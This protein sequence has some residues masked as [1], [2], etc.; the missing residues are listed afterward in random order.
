MALQTGTAVLAMRRELVGVQAPVR[1]LSTR[2]ATTAPALRQLRTATTKAGS[3]V[4]K[5]GRSAATA[6]TRIRA[7][8]GR[9]RGPLGVLGALA[10]GAGVF[11]SV[12][13]LL[14]SYTPK[15]TKF[16]TLFGTAMT[17]GSIA[18]TAINTAMKA[19]PLG[20]VL[21]IVTPLVACLVDYAVNS[22]TGQQTIQQVFQAAL[23]GFKAAWAF[24]APVIRGW[25][26]TIS[27]VFD[28]VQ[29]TVGSVLKA[30]GSAISSGFQGAGNAISSATHA[31]TS[32]V[33]GAW[34]GFKGVIQPV[35]NWL[36][37]TLPSAFTR[38]RDA[39]SKSLHGM[40]NFLSTGIQTVAG[41]V[42]GPVKGLIAFANWIIDGLN[43]LSFSFFGKKFGVHLSKIP[44]LADGGVVLPAAVPGASAVQPLSSLARFLPAP[45][46][47]SATTG[48]AFFAGRPGIRVYEE[49]EGSSPLTVADDLLFLYRTAA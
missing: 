31:V 3:A 38:V 17:L 36:T 40:G 41:V 32:I 11:G 8:A 20:F 48:P 30:V 33:R 46:G 10:A 14:G 15:V 6:A 34:N 18:M 4:R 24:M 13:D 44:Q 28:G 27:E 19:N 25:A 42:T 26:K 39:M 9:I 7:G 37:R 47:A 43:H 12:T 23:N 5:A 35:M 49:R 2:A 16:M 1:T 45:S 21:A 22:E 29:K